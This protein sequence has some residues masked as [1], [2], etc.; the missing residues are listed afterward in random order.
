LHGLQQ[1]AETAVGEGALC[2]H[3]ENTYLRDNS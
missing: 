1:R 2:L 3:Y